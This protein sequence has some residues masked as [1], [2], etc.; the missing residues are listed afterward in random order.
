MKAMASILC[1]FVLA[2]VA[3]SSSFANVSKEFFPTDNVRHYCQRMGCD[4]PYFYAYLKSHQKKYCRSRSQLLKGNTIKIL[5]VVASIAE[6]SG[7]HGSVAVLPL[8]ESGLN[9]KSNQDNEKRAKGFWQL[10]PGTARDMNLIVN[11]S[12][13][14]RLDVVKSTQAAMNLLIQL[15][16]RFGGNHNLAIMAYNA[17][18]S[19]VESLIRKYNSQNPWYLAKMMEDEAPDEDYLSKYYTYTLVILGDACRAN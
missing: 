17:G 15:K 8:M 10:M 14:E 11:S 7:L 6:Q 12:V 4:T 2:I 13:D 3:S 5:R 19:R 16:K 9:S 18:P 1:S